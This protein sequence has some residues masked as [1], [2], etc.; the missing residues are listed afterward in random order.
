M[1]AIVLR[2]RFNRLLFGSWSAEELVR[3][4]SKKFQKLGEDEHNAFLKDLFTLRPEAEKAIGERIV[5]SFNFGTLREA[6]IGLLRSGYPECIEFWV[7][8]KRI[9]KCLEGRQW[10]IK[11]SP[12]FSQK[13]KRKIIGDLLFMEGVDEIPRE[14]MVS[15]YALK[16]GLNAGLLVNFIVLLAKTIDDYISHRSLDLNL[17]SIVFFIWILALSL[18]VLYYRKKV[19]YI[20]QKKE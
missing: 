4:V 10:I 6:K 13:A 1:P 20:V 2:M 15:K 17:P 16:N 8:S 11:S 9:E 3:F 12:S 7:Y 19:A 18:T 5:A 14:D